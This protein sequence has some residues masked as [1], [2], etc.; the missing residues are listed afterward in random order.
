MKTSA[1][2]GMIL[3]QCY[4]SHGNDLQWM[5][6]YPQKSRIKQ[7]NVYFTELDHPSLGSMIFPLLTHKS[8]L[9]MAWFLRSRQFRNTTNFSS[10]SSSSPEGC[11]IA[12][13]MLWALRSEKLTRSSFGEKS[14][15]PNFDL[16]SCTKQAR[17]LLSY[18][19]MNNR[20]T[21][22]LLWV[23]FELLVDEEAPVLLLWMRRHKSLW[24]GPRVGPK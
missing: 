11:L 9:T 14:A 23:M 17:G 24:L 3:F 21:K 18:A 15:R 7:K 5:Y 22:S 20:S 1:N 10:S 2:S 16:I 8:S 6:S 4:L 19:H 12:W 13:N